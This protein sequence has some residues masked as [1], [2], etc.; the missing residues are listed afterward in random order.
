[1]WNNLVIKQF[2]SGQKSGV[3]ASVLPEQVSVIPVMFSSIE[4]PS[5]NG[6]WMVFKDL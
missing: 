2:D 3:L 5:W 6:S 4:N 1:M